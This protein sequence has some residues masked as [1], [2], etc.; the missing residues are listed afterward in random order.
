MP[1]STATASIFTALD[2]CD[3][4]GAQAYIKVTLNAGTELLFCA[5]HGRVHEDK[6][7]QVAI[8]IHDE[9]DNLNKEDES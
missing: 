9:T 3:A 5:H 4:C 8:S 6:L 2:R 7:R 1:A